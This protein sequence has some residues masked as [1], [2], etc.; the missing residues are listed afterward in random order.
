[1]L[2][3]PVVMLFSASIKSGNFNLGQTGNY[4][5][6]PTNSEIALV[7]QRFLLHNFPPA[8]GK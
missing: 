8:H 4:Y 5:F 3:T 6:G 1:M 7:L 2:N